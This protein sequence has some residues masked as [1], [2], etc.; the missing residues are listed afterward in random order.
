MNEACGISLLFNG[1]TSWSDFF[2]VDDVKMATKRSN[3]VIRI[4]KIEY[5]R[6]HMAVKGIASMYSCVIFIFIRCI[7][8]SFVFYIHTFWHC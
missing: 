6:K 3:G 8:L 7:K 5:G 2:I 4:Y 1:P